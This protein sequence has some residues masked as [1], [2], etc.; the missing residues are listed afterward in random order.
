MLFNA[1]KVTAAFELPPPKPDPIGIFLSKNKRFNGSISFLITGDEE[2]DAI[3]GTKKIGAKIIQKKSEIII[4]GVKKIKNT[5]WIFTPPNTPE[6][7]RPPP[8]SPANSDYSAES[9][10]PLP[11]PSTMKPD[12]SS[13]EEYID[14]YM[15]YHEKNQNGDTASPTN[16]QGIY[17]V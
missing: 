14:I 10:D 12:Y 1:N 13:S 17:E 16:N 9:H 4:Q 8:N 3:N 7:N 11:S 2:G 15:E 6:S 5:P